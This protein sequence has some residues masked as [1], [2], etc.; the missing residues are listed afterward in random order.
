MFRLPNLLTGH[1]EDLEFRDTR[2]LIELLYQD[3]DG[4]RAALT[5]LLDQVVIHPCGPGTEL[6][7]IGTL[8]RVI[9]PW[10]PDEILNL[11]EAEKDPVPVQVTPS[12]TVDRLGSG[13][14]I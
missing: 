4:S 8:G 10:F 11:L 7:L 3:I 13:G 6:E 14:R 12:G 5:T 1:K 2:A 9:T